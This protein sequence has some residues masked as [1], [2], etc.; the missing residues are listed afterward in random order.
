MGLVAYIDIDQTIVN[1]AGEALPGACERI[2]Q[3]A[4]Q[5]GYELV[6]W[7]RT[8]RSYALETLERLGIAKWFMAFLTKPDF[9]IDDDPDSIM[10]HA[11]I[12]KVDCRT[13]WRK[14]WHKLDGRRVF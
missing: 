9:V 8:G 7:S 12:L 10:G 14:F 4:V 11:H 13:F 6:A 1:T 5:Y 2:E 3:L